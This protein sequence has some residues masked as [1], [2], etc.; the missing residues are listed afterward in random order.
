MSE[1]RLT[2]S[3]Q[4]GPKSQLARSWQES[5]RCCRNATADLVSMQYMGGFKKAANRHVTCKV[6][7]HPPADNPIDTASPS[8]PF[9]WAMPFFLRSLS[10]SASAHFERTSQWT[11]WMFP[12]DT[13]R[14]GSLGCGHHGSR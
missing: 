9:L 3:H 2:A 10:R 11:P 4:N 13:D 5:S 8:F 7:E 1:K 6:V 14:S 12:I